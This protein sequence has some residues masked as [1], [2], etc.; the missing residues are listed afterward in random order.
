M[1][2]ISTCGAPPATTTFVDRWPHLA[3]VPRGVRA[4]AGRL[5]AAAL[6]RRAAQRVALRVEL[7][8]GTMFGGG[9][10]DPTARGWSC[11]IRTRS[12][13]GSARPASSDSARR[14]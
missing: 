11:T 1:T 3:E 13:P 12:P 2:T 5:V 8:D 4:G 6:F 7:P 14:T 10:D 9:V